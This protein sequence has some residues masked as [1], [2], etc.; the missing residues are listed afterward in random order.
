MAKRGHQAAWLAGFGL[1]LMALSLGAWAQVPDAPTLPEGRDLVKMIF[2]VDPRSF[3]TLL[4]NPEASLLATLS[5]TANVIA[6]LV[7]ALY[8]LYYGVIFA[9]RAASRGEADSNRDG[10]WVFSRG[11][12]ALMFCA[13]LAGGYS[14]LQVAVLWVAG[15]SSYV[16]DTAWTKMSSEMRAEPAAA[17]ATTWLD[18][19][20]GI[21]WDPA[22]TKNIARSMT[23]LATAADLYDGT[24]VPSV[25]Y[26]R[27]NTEWYEIYMDRGTRLTWTFGGNGRETGMPNELPEGVCGDVSLVIPHSAGISNEGYQVLME[28]LAADDGAIERYIRAAGEASQDLL[29]D[30]DSADVSLAFSAAEAQFMAD[31]RNAVAAAI[32]S[33]GGLPQTM[34]DGVMARVEPSGWVAAGA[35]YLA[36]AQYERAM[37]SFATTVMRSVSSNGP[38]REQMPPAL[39]TAFKDYDRRLEN[40]MEARIN[41]P[42]D[43]VGLV[44]SFVETV[45]AMGSCSAATIGLTDSATCLQR[46]TGRLWGWARDRFLAMGI[47][48]GYEGD[49]LAA[50]QGFGQMVFNVGTAAAVAGF[51]GEVAGG[52]LQQSKTPLVGDVTGGSGKLIEEASSSIKLI[53][54]ALLGIGIML[55]YYLPTIPIVLWATGVVMWLVTVVQVVLTSPVWAVLHAAGEGEGLAGDRARLGYQ[56]VLSLLSRPLM[57]LGGLFAGLLVARIGLGLVGYFFAVFGDTFMEGVGNAIGIIVLLVIFALA[58]TAIARYAFSLIYTLPDWAQRLTGAHEFG[59][60]V[61]EH[62]IRQ[63]VAGLQGEFR[64]FAGAFSGGKLGAGLGSVVRGRRG[65]GRLR[66]G[67]P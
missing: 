66:K 47:G 55:G 18:E 9:V 48:E 64:Q 38:K 31:L 11:A 27:R 62:N 54:F 61:Q 65:V 22:T 24:S 36:A 23:C 28:R 16:A 41:D 5:F 25:G 56:M 26:R 2:G 1:C 3:A 53:G 17:G 45:K 19:I 15:V 59:E 21:S 40:V 4:Q 29:R 32:A 46:I 14:F 49:P 67:K 43:D 60:G 8:L 63:A 42:D 50:V 34:F 12:V 44:A 35:T 57:M 33:D 10:V 13:P 39:V 37:I 30:D 7:A 52:M 6:A 20:A 58:A 51:A